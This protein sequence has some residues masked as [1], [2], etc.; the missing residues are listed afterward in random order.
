VV[1]PACGNAFSEKTR[2]CPSDGT[3]LYPQTSEGTQLLPNFEF[4]GEIGCGGMGVVYKARHCVLDKWFAIKMLPFEHLD[5]LGVRR[6]QQEARAASSLQHENVV[7]VHDCGVTA[8]GRP[9]MVMEY[10]PGE[11]LAELLRRKGNLSVAEA[12]PIFVQICAGVDHAHSKGILH[13][14]LKPSN[15]VLVDSGTSLKAKILDFGIAKILD[16]E[17]RLEKGLTQTGEVFGSPPYMSPEQALGKTADRRADIYSL[18]CLMYEVLTGAPPIVGQSVI[19]TIY[20]QI[21]EVPPSLREASLGLEFPQELEDIIAKALAKDMDRRF[22]TVE[23]LKQALACLQSGTA[24]ENVPVGAAKSM[25]GKSF[26]PIVVMAIAVLI[27]L[28]LAAFSLIHRGS[29]ESKT[30]LQGNI[31]GDTDLRTTAK[32]VSARAREDTEMVSPLD[33]LPLSADEVAWQTITRNPRKTSFELSRTRLTNRGL[34]AFLHRDDVTDLRVA[35][36]PIDDEGIKSI[37]HLPLTALDLAY[38]KVSDAGIKRISSAT[39]LRELHLEGVKITDTGLAAL[40]KLKVLSD[41]FIGSDYNLTDRSWLTLS[42]M[43]SLQV[44]DL[45][46]DS[47]MPEDGL[48]QLRSLPLLKKLNLHGM[49]ITDKSSEVIRH[50]SHLTSLDVSHTQIGNAFVTSLDSLKLEHL[51]ISDDRIDDKALLNLPNQR[52]LSTLVLSGAEQAITD[53]GVEVIAK[54]PNLRVLY[55]DREKWITDRALL[56]LGRCQGL[57]SLTIRGAPITDAGLKNLDGLASLSNLDVLGTRITDA[58]VDSILKHDL[59]EL[60]ISYTAITDEGF[61]RLARLKNLRHLF[62]SFNPKI[63]PKA[64]AEFARQLPSCELHTHGG[65]YTDA[66]QMRAGVFNR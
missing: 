47:G 59:T 24:G 38:T 18:G 1:C 63:S 42:K 15:I 33:G 50:C 28:S 57:H 40:V 41:L 36:N 25:G 64:M 61:L 21:H 5:R 46:R 48:V 32:A 10:A 62:V 35:S 39:T 6:F 44:L 60:G 4:E 31:G 13:R 66:E 30:V 2:F 14:D 19:E 8:S 53:K 26:M 16:G 3:P 49:N 27:S 11:T 23:Q 12:L 54:I 43:K 17:V 37:A 45:S 29:G 22:S 34:L 7:V 65:S 55:L 51:N 58:G 9:Y 20:R 56:Y 52:H